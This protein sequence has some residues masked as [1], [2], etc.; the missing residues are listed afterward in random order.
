MIMELQKVDLLAPEP[1]QAGLQRSCDSLA[2]A[3]QFYR[4]NAHLGTDQYIGLQGREHLAEIFL[5]LSAAVKRRRIEVVDAQLE[6]P[7]HRA[8]LICRRSTDHQPAHHAASKPQRRHLE[9]R[10]AKRSG[11]H[12]PFPSRNPQSWL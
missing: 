12:C 10:L 7:R 2:D 4:G 5:G 3:P 9:S 11:F 6:R 8:L 1:S